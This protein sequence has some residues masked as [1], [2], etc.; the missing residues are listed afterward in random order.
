[1][2]NEEESV[3]IVFLF[4]CNIVIGV[5][6]IKE[7]PGS[8]ASGTPCISACFVLKNSMFYPKHPLI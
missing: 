3:Y 6:I 4:R 8:V 5:G 1:M 7:M 2:R